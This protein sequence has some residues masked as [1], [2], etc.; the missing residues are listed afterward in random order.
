MESDMTLCD[1]SYDVTSIFD[2]IHDYQYQ[3]N[4]HLSESMDNCE[5]LSDTNMPS[6]NGISDQRKKDKEERYDGDSNDSNSIP[7]R[8]QPVVSLF[9]K[10]E[11]RQWPWS[12]SFVHGNNSIN[13]Q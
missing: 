5:W 9:N 3:N 7:V 2:L 10:T 8:E 4:L 6:P 12:K 13:K 1:D 11:R